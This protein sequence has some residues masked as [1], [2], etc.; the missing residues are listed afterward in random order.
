ME[1]RTIVDFLA[2]LWIGTRLGL[3]VFRVI[4]KLLPPVAFVTIESINA[5]FFIVED[6]VC[7]API[8]TGYRFVLLL[9][10][11]PSIVLPVVRVDAES[12][13]MLSEVEGTP[14]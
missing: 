6:E 1:E 3:E 11:L 8:P 9:V 13:I 4:L 14:D 10:R 7:W 12:F 2:R 5:A